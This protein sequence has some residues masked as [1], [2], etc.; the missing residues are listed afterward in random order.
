MTTTV[1]VVRPSIVLP[2]IHEMFPEHLMASS[3]GYYQHPHHREYYDVPR[4]FSFPPPVRTAPPR[5][6]RA[7]SGYEHL[8][9]S[10]SYGSTTL[11]GSP[12]YSS[13]S[14]SHSSD[15][16]D[17]TLGAKKHVCPTCSKRFN[18]P[19]SLRIHVNMHTGSVQTRRRSALRHLAAPEASLPQRPVDEA[20]KRSSSRLK[21]PWEDRDLRRAV[22]LQPEDV[23][24]SEINVSAQ[25]FESP[26][27]W[28]TEA[29]IDS[30]LASWE[31]RRPL[32]SM[33]MLPDADRQ[34]L[35]SAQVRQ[36]L[37]DVEAH[38][39]ALLIHIIDSREARRAAQRLEGDRAQSFVDAIQDALD[40][41]T[42]PDS[43]SRSKA[44]HLMRK[45]SEAGEQLPSSLFITGVND[46]DE[47]PTFGGG[48]GDVYQA[49]YQGKM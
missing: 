40:R 35:S 47:H 3:P 17:F 37:E 48:F 49:S 11:A 19:S 16:E 7:R 45:V 41:G 44:R 24:E 2:S 26:A 42:L 39:S 1:A 27:S 18:R 22:Q 8:A 10:S 15:G 6:V 4:P 38:I 29:Y 14:S 23:D 25:S 12:A 33:T 31:R 32:L 21:R 20:R 13:S 28:Q 36:R 9:S 5:N 34:G 46:H 43:T 30:L